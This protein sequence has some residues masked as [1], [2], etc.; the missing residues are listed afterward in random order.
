VPLEAERLGGIQLISTQEDS[1]VVR[2]PKTRNLAAVGAQENYYS[3]KCEMTHNY[4]NDLLT[5]KLD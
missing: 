3:L 4:R 5:L 2:K 1:H